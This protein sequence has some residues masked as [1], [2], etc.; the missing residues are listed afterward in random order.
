MKI[1][2]SVK[3]SCWLLLLLLHLK[4]FAQQQQTTLPQLL[5]LAEKNYP[6]LKSKMLDIK[7]AQKGIDVSKS[8]L[9]PS[10]DASYQMDYATYNNITGMA[11]T[12][13][14]VPIS[15]PPSSSN[16]M[17][18][19]F[20]SATSLLLNWQPITFGQ[21]Q[22]QVDF[23]KAGLQYANADAENEIFQHKI[24]V[25]NAYLDVLTATELVKVYQNNLQRTEA[26]LQAVQSLVN[27]GIR[28]GVDIALFK[29]E[30]SK[31]KV[32]LLNSQKYKE[33]TRIYLSQLLATDNNISIADTLFFSKLPVITLST[34]SVKNPLINLYSS[35]I[36]IGFARKKVLSKTTMPTLGTWSTIY[37]RG[38]GISY[39]GTVKAIDGLGLQRINYGI[40]LQL[41]V[42]LLQSAR[43]RPQLQ[44][45]DFLIQSNQEKFNEI[46]LQLKKQNELADTS[47]NNAF[48]VVKESPLFLESAQFSYRAMQ[49][50]YQSGLAT[51]SDFMQAQYALIKAETD[52]KLAYMSVWK[53]FLYKAAV[54]G[55]LNLFINQVN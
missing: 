40:G 24:K 49:S 55:D 18:G 16:N 28:P 27:S 35:N 39:N 9:I 23:A 52:Y 22:A 19:V 26:N 3:V 53:A 32:E 45:Q 54:N 47:L 34:D 7:A 36:A 38:S 44:Q 10:L 5:Q 15:G 13:F 17:S 2:Q 14:L 12:Q 33:Q 51:I 29:A 1:Y 46:Q 30:D 6:L 41:S 8:T 31:A 25:I 37:A 4:G 50:R 48:A 20:G 21:R 42:P 11:Y 43:I